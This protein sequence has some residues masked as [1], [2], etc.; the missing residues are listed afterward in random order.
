VSAEALE[1]ALAAFV[2]TALVVTHD[3]W[4][5]RG[6]DRFLAFRRDGSVV[7]SLKPVWG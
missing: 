1:G 6:F 7:E 2:G 5:V 3:R 4:L